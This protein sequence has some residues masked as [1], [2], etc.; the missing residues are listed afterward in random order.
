MLNVAAIICGGCQGK[1]STVSSRAFHFDRYMLNFA[2]GLAGRREDRA[3]GEVVRRAALSGAK[4]RR[5][6]SK[7]EMLRS[8]VRQSVTPTIRSCSAICEIR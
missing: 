3:A 8:L 1:P 7:D 2:P 4:R 5:L 6:L